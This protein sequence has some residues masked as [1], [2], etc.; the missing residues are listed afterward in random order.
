MGPTWEANPDAWWHD[1]EGN[2]RGPFLGVQTVLPGMV[3][4]KRGRVITTGS[5]TSLAPFPYLTG[6]ASS[7]AAVAHFIACLAA[8][9]RQ[10]GIAVFALGPGLVRSGLTVALAEETIGQQYLPTWG[11]SLTANALPPERAAELAVFLASGRADALSGRFILVSDDVER[12]V[13]RADAIRQQNLYVLKRAT[14]P[15]DG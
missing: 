1:V 8:E 9:T 6:Y 7:K 13:Q 14:L 5:G 15:A 4:R 3:A 11:R 12:L 2:L 10:H